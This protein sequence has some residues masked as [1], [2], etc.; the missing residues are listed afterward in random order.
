M[1]LILDRPGI[2]LGVK[3]GLYYI[4]HEDGDQKLS[5]VKVHSICICRACKLTYDAV[6]LAV[7]HETEILFLDRKGS[8]QARIWSPKY[9]SISTIRKHQVAFAQSPEGVDWVKEKIARKMDNQSA[10]LSLLSGETPGWELVLDETI[11]KIEAKKISLL[12]TE[13][14]PLSTISNRLRGLEGQAGRLYFQQISQMLPDAYQFSG[15]SQHPARDMFNAMLNYGYGMLYTKVEAALIKAGLD[16]YLGIFH[17]DE[18]NRPVLAYDF[19]EPYRIWVDYVVCKLCMEQVIFPD[20][21]EIK[22]ESYWLDRPAKQILITSLNDYL[23]EIVELRQLRRSRVVHIELD[24]QQFA[25][26]LKDPISNS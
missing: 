10:L 19:I 25:N 24:A 5:P 23:A 8:P 7:K 20:F 2:S 16:P 22:E 13:G 14:S 4:S 26:R 21:F 15:R 12:S 18:Y 6:M 11:G 9:G 1:Q 17:R 3:N